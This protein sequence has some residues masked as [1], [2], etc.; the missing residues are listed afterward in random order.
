M[1]MFGITTEIRGMLL[2]SDDICRLVGQK[3]YPI[4][5]PDGT[6]GD[7]IVYQR[8]GYKQEYRKMDN[9]VIDLRKNDM[10]IQ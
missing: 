6:D 8:D 5:A 3:I 4:V 1:N 9:L 10:C 7:F 2:D